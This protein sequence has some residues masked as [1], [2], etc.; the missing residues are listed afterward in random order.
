MLLDYKAVGK[1]IAQDCEQPD[2][3]LRLLN[4]VCFVA[5]SVFDFV[6]EVLF[7]DYS[8]FSHLAAMCLY[9]SPKV[10]PAFEH[11]NKIQVSRL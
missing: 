2:V 9:C 6:H 7:A 4:W 5:A 1:H 11:K 3:N 8:L 10:S